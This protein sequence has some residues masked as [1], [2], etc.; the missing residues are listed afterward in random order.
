MNKQYQDFRGTIVNV[1]I[2]RGSIYGNPYSH[3]DSDKTL[4]A[5]KTETREEA[6]QKYSEYF[7]NR[8]KTDKEFRTEI[9]NLAEL[10]KIHQEVNLLCYCK[11]AKCHGDFLRLFLL[12]ILDN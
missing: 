11:P 9:L 10:V 3:L 8:F 2:G 12:K 4:A 6:I 5:H 1:Y 7:I